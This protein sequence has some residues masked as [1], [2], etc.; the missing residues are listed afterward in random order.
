M[1]EPT[2]EF[3][4]RWCEHIQPDQLTKTRYY[5]GWCCRKRKEYQTKCRRLLSPT[6]QEVEVALT[7]EPPA[8]SESSSAEPP[9]SISQRAC[10][11]CASGSLRLIGAIDKPSWSKVLSHLDHRC[12]AWYAEAEHQEFC[13]YLDR[14]YGISYEDWYLE[15]RIESPMRDRGAGVGGCGKGMEQ[16]ARQMY[17][18]GLEPQRDWVLESY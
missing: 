16:S 12:P 11:C 3:V 18:P 17:L 10:P 14:E 7:E 2:L 15:M 6:E 1:G 9:E 5:G 8:A 13:A 4:R